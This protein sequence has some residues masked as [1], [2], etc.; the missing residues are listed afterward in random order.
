MEK[1]NQYQYPKSTTIATN[2]NAHFSEIIDVKGNNNGYI[3]NIK[4]KSAGT[5]ISS[6]TPQNWK[7]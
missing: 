4:K 6:Y 1:K 2:Q 7:T 5:G 3:G